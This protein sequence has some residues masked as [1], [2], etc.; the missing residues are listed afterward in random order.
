MARVQRWNGSAF[1]NDTVDDS[2]PLAGLDAVTTKQAPVGVDYYVDA[3][4]GSDSNT[5]TSSDEALATIDAAHTKA[6]SGRGDRIWISPGTYAETLVVTKDYLSFLG[7]IAGGYARP[8]IGSEDGV[9]LTVRAQ[10]FVAKHCRFFAPAADVDLVI[11]E[12][13]GF[14][15]ADCVFDG[16]A[17]QGNDKALL[18]FKGNATDDGMTASEGVVTGC[19]FRG[20]GGDGIIFDTAE[21][22]VGV[23]STD[24][25]LR[26]SKF[27]AN[28]QKDIATADT[29]PG[30]YS[31]QRTQIGPGNV[32]A[33]KN[34]TCY[35][36]LTT[37]NGG[38]AGDQS[39]TIVGNHFAADAINS[40]RV[41]MVGTA[42]TFAGNSCT[43]GVV[44]G[45]GLD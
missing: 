11:Q 3:A 19:L 24:N 26:D 5:G 22:L 33:D 17:T 25:V 40:T 37:S 4:N 28:D 8:D 44:D 13:N 1:V 42:F 7:A 20:S 30:N 10:G 21:P 38:A 45:S 29:G 14:I 12:G 23:G 43:A 35:I 41:A 32:F 27:I 15:F 2:S 6:V 9:T 18:R 16:D 39:G 31:C 34:K 36:D